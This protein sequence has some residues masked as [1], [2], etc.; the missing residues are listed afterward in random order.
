MEHYFTADQWPA[1]QQALQQAGITDYQ[2]LRMDLTDPSA[3]W[4]PVPL[5]D[6]QVCAGIA[7]SDSV[8]IV[9]G[10]GRFTESHCKY[11]H[12]NHVGRMVVETVFKRQVAGTT[13]NV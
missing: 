7:Q 9:Y 8:L 12:Q 5:V 10:L 6:M 3:G 13:S 4:Q 1:V 2:R 11:E